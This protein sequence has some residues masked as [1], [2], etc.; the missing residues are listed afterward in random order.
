MIFLGF[1]EFGTQIKD[2][3]NTLS[4]AFYQGQ[5]TTYPL[6]VWSKFQLSTYGLKVGTL[7]T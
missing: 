5:I 2:G 1:S 3:Q 7:P 6:V 4:S